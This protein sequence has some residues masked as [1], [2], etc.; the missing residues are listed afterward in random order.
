MKKLLVLS[1]LLLIFTVI[2]GVCATLMTLNH[3]QSLK[4]ST[5]LVTVTESSQTQTQAEFKI[6]GLHPDGKGGVIIYSYEI[7]SL[8]PANDG[9]SDTNMILGR[10]QDT[11][12]GEDNYFAYIANCAQNTHS[13]IELKYEEAYHRFAVVKV[14]EENVQTKAD[15]IAYQFSLAA[16]NVST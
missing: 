3:P 11:L 1:G 15:T 7:H 12:T 4:P 9:S 5:S 6:L 8:Q 2:G 10:E 14:I 13:I 16:C